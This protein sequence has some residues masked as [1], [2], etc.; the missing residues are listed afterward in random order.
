MNVKKLICG[1]I[2]LALLLLPA[3]GCSSSGAKPAVQLVPQAA[4]FVAVVQVGNLLN[5]KELM[6]LNKKDNPE[7]DDE[8]ASPQQR[9]EEF[10]EETGIDLKTISELVVF[11]DISDL[12]NPG[13][14]YMGCIARGSYD[15]ELVIKNFENEAGKELNTTVYG[16]YT[17]YSSGKD[18]YSLTFIDD[19]MMVFGTPKAVT[20]T[21]DVLTKDQKPLSGPVIDTC[22]RLGDVY[23]KAAVDVKA[24]NQTMMNQDAFD[25]IPVNMS[26]FTQV[27]LV[28]FVF[29]KEKEDIKIKAEMHYLDSKSLKDGE[30]AFRGIIGLLKG[31][32]TNAE[33]K[34]FLEKIQVAS[35]NSWLTIS[36]TTTVDE[37]RNASEAMKNQ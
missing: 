17:L 21:L 2:A 29:D 22:N 32:A 34:N 28:G 13:T 35:A 33:F 4:N 10:A 14:G 7:E 12:Q 26:M 25:E 16:E 3:A 36:L 8:D 15:P 20:D 18:R 9:L 5:D 24:A 11:G 1:L 6:E 37:L 30:D 23:L 27:D 19:D 31:F